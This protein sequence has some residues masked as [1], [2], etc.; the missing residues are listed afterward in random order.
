MT[1]KS[2]ENVIWSQSSRKE[3][4]PGLQLQDLTIYPENGSSFK[5]HEFIA[6]GLPPSLR[7]LCFM[8]WLSPFLSSPHVDRLIPELHRVFQQRPL[9]QDFTDCVCVHVCLWEREKEIDVT[10]AT[11]ITGGEREGGGIV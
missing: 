5:I 7:P 2:L 11:L 10:P 6:T 8:L 4:E 9:V 3:V 1:V